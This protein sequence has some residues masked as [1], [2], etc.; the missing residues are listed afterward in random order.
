MERE[1]RT[2]QLLAVSRILL[3]QESYSDA[4]SSLFLSLSPVRFC[5][6]SLVMQKACPCVVVLLVVLAFALCSAQ[7]STAVTCNLMDLSPCLPAM[8][9]PAAPTA[10][11]CSKL[12]QQRSCFCGYLRD[13]KYKAYRQYLNSPNAKKVA[14]TCRVPFP[15]C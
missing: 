10:G 14:T 3:I 8:T 11:C 6:C 1:F 15:K 5:R 12:R 7:V 13:P 4:P 2:S 9:S